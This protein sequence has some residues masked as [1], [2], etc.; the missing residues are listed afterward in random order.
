[1][2]RKILIVAASELGAS[3]RSKAFIISVILMPI[4][5]GGSILIQRLTA[6]HRD[7]TERRFAVVDHTGKL[8]AP[9]AAATAARNDLIANGTV[10][11]ARFTPFEIAPAP[12]AGAD[13]Q[14]LELSGRVKSGSLWAFVDIPA[15]TLS[16]GDARIRYHSDHPTDEELRMWIDLVTNQVIRAQRFAEAGLDAA[17]VAR[18]E[19]PVPTDHLG[20]LARGPGGAVR[21]AS[22]VDQVRN[23]LIPIVFMFLVFIIV[24]TSAP[25]L[26][27]S[28]LEEKMNRISEV[29]LGSVTPFELMLGKLCGSAGIT[30]ILAAI[31]LAGG[32]IAAASLGY[33]GAIPLDLLP[34]LVL[35]L[36][37][38]IFLFGSLYIAVGAACSELKDA[39]SLMMPVVVVT[40]MPIMLWTVVLRAPAS[41]L[42]VIFSL[43]PPATP[44]L[45]LLRMALHP[46]P[47]LWQV[48]LS[49]VLCAL[50]TLGCVFAAGRIFRAGVLMQGKPA[51]MRQMLRWVMTR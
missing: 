23:L 34:W 39:Q 1:M 48:V 47:P 51:S 7:T 9:L 31:Y 15:D 46:G 26:L 32:A 43:L 5:T 8:Y 29:L 41:N 20:L 44:F 42:S 25:Q 40:V 13:A 2:S 12:A 30:L 18:L 19:K 14:R 10:A 33:L 49:V 50:T 45:M 37:L 6:G 36:L 28:V 11:G 3:L 35:F 27:N 38:A 24:M 17:L 16:G 4:L 21:E 22:R